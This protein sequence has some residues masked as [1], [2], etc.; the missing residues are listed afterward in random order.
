[1]TEYIVLIPDN[2]D[3]WA[4]ADEAEQAAGLRQARRV[5]AGAGRPRPQDDRRRRAHPAAEGRRRASRRDGGLSIT[6]GPYA[7]SAEQLSGFY[8]I[9]TDDLDDLLQVVG[10]LAEGEGALE[11]RP[12]LT[13]GRL[14]EDAC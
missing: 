3:T 7:E 8:V 10:I 12:C 9:E 11:V 13:R 1:M 2:E 5:R 6:E 14:R 4:I